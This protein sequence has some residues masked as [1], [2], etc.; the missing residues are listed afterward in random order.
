[1]N[2]F[3]ESGH[4]FLPARTLGGRDPGIFEALG[5]DSEYGEELL[6]YLEPPPGVKVALGIMAVPGMAARNQDAVGAV[7][8]RFDYEK[9]IDPARAGDTYDT[10][11][12]GLGKTPNPGRVGPA[13]GT[14]VAEKPDDPQFFA[15]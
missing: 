7:Q 5:I 3:G 14:P 10:Q 6:E 15:F 2:L 8:Q 12:R 13:V 1:M 9:R 11:V 4:H